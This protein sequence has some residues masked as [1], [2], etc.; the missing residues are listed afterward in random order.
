MKT[1]RIICQIPTR[2]AHKAWTAPDQ[3]TKQFQH[4]A[5]EFAKCAA[6]NSHR[7]AEEERRSR[8]VK[9]SNSPTEKPV[10]WTECDE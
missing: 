3:S 4:E 7:Q 1:T 6:D 8:V 2:G 10:D 9:A 5:D